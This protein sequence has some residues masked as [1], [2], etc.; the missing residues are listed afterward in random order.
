LS[1]KWLPGQVISGLTFNKK[2]FDIAKLKLAI[3]KRNFNFIEFYEDLS[4]DPYTIIPEFRLP[5]ESRDVF[6]KRLNRLYANDKPFFGGYAEDFGFFDRFIAI[7]QEFW[8]VESIEILKLL[9]PGNDLDDP[10]PRIAK[11]L[12]LLFYSPGI[13]EYGVATGMVVYEGKQCYR[14]YKP[15]ISGDVE[16]F[17]RILKIDLRKKPESVDAGI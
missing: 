1:T 4:N 11:G 2:D 13:E 9:H 7:A 8:G 12:P 3:V 10:H 15:N 6:L 17:E 5:D 16:R 14:H